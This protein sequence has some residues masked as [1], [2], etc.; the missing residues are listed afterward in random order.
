[1]GRV[2]LSGSYLI[3]NGWVKT[4][5][6]IDGNSVAFF[7][8]LDTTI[9]YDGCFWKLGNQKIQYTDQIL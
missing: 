1:M 8:K 5:N 2:D 7:Q 6:R 3:A 9:T 4:V